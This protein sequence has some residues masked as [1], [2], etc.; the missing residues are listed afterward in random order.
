MIDGLKPL[1]VFWLGEL[2]DTVNRCGSTI[3]RGALWTQKSIEEFGK[4][5]SLYLAS[6]LQQLV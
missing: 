3:I 2:K 1:Y 6:G 5:R 4:R